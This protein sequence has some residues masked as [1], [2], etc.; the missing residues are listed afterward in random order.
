MVAVKFLLGSGLGAAIWLGLGGGL[1]AVFAW[2]T[3]LLLRLQVYFG[4]VEG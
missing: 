3:L 2:Q 1:K 4:V